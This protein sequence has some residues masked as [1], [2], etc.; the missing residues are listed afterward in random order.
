MYL[1]IVFVCVYFVLLA[2]VARESD[3]DDVIACHRGLAVATTWST[4]RG[5]MGKH[6][7]LHKRLKVEEHTTVAQVGVLQKS[8]YFDTLLY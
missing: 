8:R 1:F 6:K 4:Q 2:E 5:C 3:W 7:L